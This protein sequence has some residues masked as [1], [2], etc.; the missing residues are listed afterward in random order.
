[1]DIFTSGILIQFVQTQSSKLQNCSMEHILQKIRNLEKHTE[2]ENQ[3]L[4]QEKEKYL[5][6]Q[7]KRKKGKLRKFKYPDG[8]VQAELLETKKRNLALSEEVLH[9][10]V[11]VKDL[12]SKIVTAKKYMKELKYVYFLRIITLNLLGAQINAR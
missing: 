8:L 6:T 9:K 5:K 12:E 1:M 4:I 7:E 3:L 11:Q 2:R 10:E